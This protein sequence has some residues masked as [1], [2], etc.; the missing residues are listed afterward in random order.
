MLTIEFE[1]KWAD[2]WKLRQFI[3]QIFQFDLTDPIEH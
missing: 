1:N 2:Y 3:N